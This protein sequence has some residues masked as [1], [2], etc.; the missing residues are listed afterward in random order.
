MRRCRH[1]SAALAI[2][3]PCRAYD[4][5]AVP[6][7]QRLSPR[8]GRWA[9]EPAHSAPQAGGDSHFKRPAV[10]VNRTRPVN[11]RM[12][13]VHPARLHGRVLGRT[14]R[15]QTV[16]GALLRCQRIA[17]AE[18]S[19]PL[20]RSSSP[21]SEFRK[22]PTLLPHTADSVRKLSNTCNNP[23]PG[24]AFAQPDK[25]MCCSGGRRYGAGRRRKW[26]GKTTFAEQQQRNQSK[27]ANMPS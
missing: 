23:D 20:N 12:G 22:S 15:T 1:L 26:E 16:V 25:R 10:R 9:R 18:D 8:G 3:V 11:P 17:E 7:C 13:R 24:R 27:A 4:L 19:P 21:P 6:F 2:R 5:R 14:Q